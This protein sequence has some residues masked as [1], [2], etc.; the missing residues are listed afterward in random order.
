MRLND[1]F[2]RVEQAFVDVALHGALRNTK[3]LRQHLGVEPVP[4]DELAQ[5]GVQ[6]EGQFVVFFHFEN[7]SIQN[8]ES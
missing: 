4:L 2:Q 5:N 8:I 3:L 1:L 6:A 7:F